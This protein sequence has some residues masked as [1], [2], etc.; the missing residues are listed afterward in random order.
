MIYKIPWWLRDIIMNNPNIML[1]NKEL[2]IAS[3]N[4][5]KIS[6][7]NNLIKDYDIKLYSIEDFNIKEPKETGL[8]FIENAIIKARH[9]AKYSSIPALADDS[10]LIVDI[11]HGEP[12]IYSARYAKKQEDISQDKANINKLIAK[13]KKFENHTYPFTARFVC[14]LAFVKNYHD[15]CP[16]IIQKFWE[17]K[18]ILN[19]CGDSGFGYDPVFFIPEINKT[20]A[21][22]TKNEKQ[23]IS[24][25][26]LAL[27]EFVK[28]LQN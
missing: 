3:G 17:G 18:I 25:R 16:I 28:L 20:A 15:P 6:E 22:L 14:V 1:K 4:K 10:G 26:G 12:G 11:L 24:H 8:S 7:I 27:K 19:P 13:L 9:A 23:E 21:E 5:N 2:L